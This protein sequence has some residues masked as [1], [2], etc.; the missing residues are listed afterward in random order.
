MGNGL[1]RHFLPVN[2]KHTGAALAGAWA[3]VFK[4]EHYRVLAGRE[5]GGEQAMPRRSA[6]PAV[7]S[8]IEQVVIKNRLP[9]QQIEAVAAEASAQSHDHSFRTPLWNRDLGGDG[10]V[11]VQ[12]AGRVAHRNVGVR[13]RISE[14][15][16]ARDRARPW[17]QQAC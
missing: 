7:M 4:V 5:R 17:R 2:S 11:L 13:S 8:Q 1:A 9:L 10:V 12:D 15:G 14:N 16:P 6:F 3:V